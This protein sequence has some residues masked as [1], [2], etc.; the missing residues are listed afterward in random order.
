MNPLAEL[1]VKVSASPPPKD[2]PAWQELLD[3][4][5][6]TIK[7]ALKAAARVLILLEEWLL[8]V[9]RNWPRAPSRRLLKLEEFH[10]GVMALTAVEEVEANIC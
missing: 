7:R 3:R 2:P 4:G 5:V 6:E 8:E 1:L 10:P 9:H